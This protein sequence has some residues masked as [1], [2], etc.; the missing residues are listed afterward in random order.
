MKRWS[1]QMEPTAGDPTK[2][3]SEI[4]R[5]ADKLKQSLERETT[6]ATEAMHD[7]RDAARSKT[8]ELAAEAKE[9]ALRR[10]EDAQRQASTS[11]HTF[12]E[13]VRTAGNQLAE[14]EQ[15]FAARLVREAANGFEELSDTLSR[16][17]PQQIIEDVR[18]FGRRNPTAF[19]AGT[20]LAGLA[21]GR[22]IASS[23]SD[24]GASRT[25]SSSGRRESGDGRNKIGDWA[26]P[27]PQ[28]SGSS[29]QATQDKTGRKQ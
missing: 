25:S 3:R 2:P 19:F 21:L 15:G 12:A 16:K 11:L 5:D 10:A 4:E 27:I 20:V 23:A 22:L 14:S 18:D 6:A 17:H 26:T 29:S 1:A 13:A 9:G 28:R 7:L 8:S 24:D